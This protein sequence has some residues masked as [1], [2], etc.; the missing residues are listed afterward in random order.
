M[1]IVAEGTGTRCPLYVTCIYDKDVTEADCELSGCDRCV[2]S[3]GRVRLLEV[4]NRVTAHNKEHVDGFSNVPLRLKVRSRDVQ[5]MFFV[6]LPGIITTRGQGNDNRSAIKDILKTEMK[7]NNTKLLVLLE[8]KE[9][10]T[11]SIIDFVDESLGS[12]D[13]WLSKSLFLMTKFDLRIGDSLTG[14][15]TNRFFDEYWANN[16]NP[17]MVITPTMQRSADSMSTDEQFKER[18][19]LLDKAT[20]YE[21]DKFDEWEDAMAR[22]YADDARAEEFAEHLRPYVGFSAAVSKMNRLLLDDTR[23]RLPQV[24]M[25][26]SAKRNKAS[27]ELESLKQ[28]LKFTEADTIQLKMAE[29]LD[30]LV[31]RINGYLDG[32]LHVAKKLPQLHQTLMDEIDGEEMSDWAKRDLNHLTEAEDLWRDH[33]ASMAVSSGWPKSV[34][35]DAKFLGGKQ[36]QR[37]L[38]FFKAVMIDRLPEPHSLRPY[39]MTACG[40]LRGGLNHEDWEHATVEIIKT[41]V[42][43]V[44]EAGTNFFVKHILYIFRRM[45]MVAFEDLKSGELCSA[46]F[47]HLPKGL[48]HWIVQKYDE[49]LWDLGKHAVGNCHTSMEPFYSTVHP[50]LPTMANNTTESPQLKGS[51]SQYIDVISKN[52]VEKLYHF[53]DKRNWEKIQQFG[54]LYSWQWLV[55]HNHKIP[56]PGGNVLSREMVTKRGVGDFVHLSFCREHPMRGCAQL[57]GR[58]Q[59]CVLLAIDPV[60]VTWKD[61]LFS[62]KDVTQTGAQIGATLEDLINVDFGVAKYTEEQAAKDASQEPNRSLHK[63]EVM[64]KSHV[65]LQYISM[66][67]EFPTAGGIVNTIVQAVRSTISTAKS[68]MQM[69][70]ENT[71]LQRTEFLPAP[72]ALMIC[73]D[74]VSVILD[75]SYK[76]ILALFPFITTTLEFQFSHFLFVEFKSQLQK[77]MGFELISSTDW[78]ALAK[79]DEGTARRLRELEA[80]VDALTGALA[81]VRDIEANAPG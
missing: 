79:P 2:Q 30:E 4:F 8:P 32:S 62:D 34:H 1:N 12:R 7:V 5:N 50:S 9:F 61:T 36:Y 48:H 67:E 16:I 33:L 21:K 77:R 57:D 49:M 42:R 44:S 37:A 78:K 72:R 80:Q 14:S 3:G 74:E 46:M 43:S 75:R 29:V 17:F 51:W 68:S 22:A 20:S 35:M 38:N 53:T 47:R 81:T 69:E 45:L 10:A 28:V 27:E 31:R 66:V 56:A 58:I 71:A 60:V 24:L 76:Y 19:T 52:H 64:V 18:Q 40:T 55:K 39:V 15:K 13:A 70:A 23:G 41:C 11:N 63:A 59:D 54:G 25:E 6:D 65:P 73:D 26:L